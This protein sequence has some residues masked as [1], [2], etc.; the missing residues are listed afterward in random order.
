MADQWIGKY[1]AE[2]VLGS[3]SFAT[4][5][6][7]F[8]DRLDD[9]VA[10]KVLADNWA[11]NE[12]VRRRFTDEAKTMRRIDDDAVVRIHLVDELPDGRPYF[13]MGWADNGTLQDRMRA[14]G[15][16]GKVFEVREAVAIGAAIAECLSVVHQHKVI[17]RDIKPSNVLFRSNRSNRR[18]Q[19]GLSDEVLMLGDF[20]LAKSLA[21]SA[22]FTVAAGTP[23]YMAPEQAAASDDL[24]ERADVYGVAAIVYELLSG[25]TP[26]PATTLSGVGRIEERGRLRALD[27]LN[28]RVPRRLAQVVEL[29][30]Q[31]DRSRRTATAALFADELRRALPIEDGTSTALSSGPAAA[32]PAASTVAIRGPAAQRRSQDDSAGRRH[33]QVG[34]GCTR[35]AACD[36]GHAPAH[37][38]DAAARA[39][40]VLAHRGRGRTYATNPGSSCSRRGEHVMGWLGPGG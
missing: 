5:W 34:A 6:L 7:A 18:R 10:I 12:D 28:G 26:F 31:A 11:L 24:D 38:G 27:E 21:G 4:V 14:G 17:H 37:G 1:R 30:L 22:G 15:N 40:E 36:P 13:V 19:A 25:R 9:R 39:G 8:D 29:G 35:V 33:H 23:A 20:G 3:G 16:T 2:K 32:G